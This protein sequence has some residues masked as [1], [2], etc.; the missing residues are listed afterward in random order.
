[1]VKRAAFARALALDPRI[2]FLDEPTSDLDPLAAGGIDTLILHM[3]RSLGVTVVVVTHDLNTLFTVCSRVAI[4]VDRKLTVDTLAN[5]MKS[6]QPWIHELLHGPRAQRA[7]NARKQT[8]GN[9]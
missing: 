4:L 5:L 7:T 6:E 9:G 2:V 8:H 3:N 1:M